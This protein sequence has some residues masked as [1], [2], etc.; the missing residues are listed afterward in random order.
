MIEA[1]DRHGLP[2]EASPLFPFQRINNEY[3]APE[4]TEAYQGEW[5]RCLAFLHLPNNVEVQE[6]REIQLQVYKVPAFNTSLPATV[7]AI[8]G[9]NATLKCQVVESIPAVVKFEFV[10]NG[11]ILQT[12]HH[13]TV[14]SHL[15]KQYAE[16]HIWNVTEEDLGEYVCR[17]HN[18]EMS[19]EMELRLMKAGEYKYW[20][21]GQVAKAFAQNISLV[22]FSPTQRTKSRLP[23]QLK[24]YNHVGNP[25]RRQGSRPQS[26]F[27]FCS[28]WNKA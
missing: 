18:R 26:P 1:N 3:T 28:L 8:E 16:L 20:V 11:E 15:T 22:R 21:V 23:R 24:R 17:V 19:N 14:K 10:R 6:T 2:L 12:N 7:F 4:L 27:L 25:E 13:H 9:Q 5:I